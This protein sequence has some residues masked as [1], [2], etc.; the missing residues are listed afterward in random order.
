MEILIFRKAIADAVADEWDPPLSE[1]LTGLGPGQHIA[2]HIARFQPA[3]QHL[4]AR[5]PGQP[6]KTLSQPHTPQPGPSG[7]QTPVQ[8]IRAWTTPWAPPGR[9]IAAPIRKSGPWP[10]RTAT[11]T[12]SRPGRAAKGSGPKQAPNTWPG[13][14]SL[15]LGEYLS[16]SLV[17]LTYVRA[18][19]STFW[20]GQAPTQAWAGAWVA[21]S[22]ELNY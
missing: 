16:F 11:L 7:S 1:V 19:R 12:P 4:L 9:R 5:M 22:L 10:S 15:L 14:Y 6:P 17:W 21:G 13:E 18:R 20:H 2:L 3:H 8:G